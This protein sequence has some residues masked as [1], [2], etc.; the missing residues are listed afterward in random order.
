[1]NYYLVTPLVRVHSDDTFTYHHED[2]MPAGTIVKVEVGRKSA[3]GV[4]VGTTKKPQF[5]TK[6]IIQKLYDTPLPSAL[7]SLAD[8]MSDYYLSPKTN[9]W[10]TILPRGL[11]KK[12][13]DPRPKTASFK[14]DHSNKVLTAEQKRVISE[15]EHS[16]QTTTLLQGVTGSG[17]TLIYHELVKRCIDSGQ[18]AIL[19]VPEIA[20]TSQLVADFSH[21]FKNILLIHS[22]MSEAERHHAW[23]NALEAK[24]P[25]VVIGPR[26]ALFTPL[27][28]IGIIVIDEAH[29]PSFKQEQAPRYSTQRAARVLA[30]HHKAK[31]I[32]GSATPSV[33]DRYLAE[34]HNSFVRI[35][36]SPVEIGT[37]KT[38]LVDNTK[39]IHFT[40]HRFLSNQLIKMIDQTLAHNEQVLLFHN[41]RGS[42]AMTLCENCGWTAEC[43]RCH[44]P[45]TLH[46]DTYSL[47]CHVCNYATKVPTQCPLCN[48]TDIIHKGVGTKLIYDEVKRL[49]PNKNIVRFDKDS[50][51]ESTLDKLY[52]SVHDGNIDIIIGTQTIAKGLDLPRL[53]AVGVIQADSGLSLPD[54]TA[55]ERVFQLLYQVIGRVGRNKN[56][57][58]AVIQTYKPS[59]PAIAHALTKDYD[60]FYEH[61]LDERRHDH[62]PPF[63]F[64]ARLTCSYSSEKGASQAARSLKQKLQKYAGPEVIFLGPSPAFYERV[65]DQYKWQLILRSSKR[66]SLTALLSHMPSTHWQAEL[67]PVSLL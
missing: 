20:L 40:K 32:L 59:H 64:L 30:G 21:H 51:K 31:L 33:T 27:K 10:Q 34:S 61:T 29:E 19:L 53:S 48:H 28:N 17:K 58:H 54:F 25:I 26:S 47:L 39:R 41:R 18:S 4:I 62:F 49:Y 35:D 67:D 55:N 23:Q 16:T 11:D 3:I 50:D 56:E 14:R 2:T 60:T 5:S 43:P 12:R 22:R 65:R 37:L 38:T 6:S 13:R 36:E 45:L 44:L 46:T 66:E 57:S 8:W 1:M 7:L 9:T 63:T 52:Q 42:T 15:I 24:Q